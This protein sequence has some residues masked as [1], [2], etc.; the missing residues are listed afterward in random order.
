[1]GSYSAMQAWDIHTIKE[2]MDE[3]STCMY[4]FWKRIAHLHPIIGLHTTFSYFDQF[5][6]VILEVSNNKVLKEFVASNK[7]TWCYMV[8]SG[9]AIVWVETGLDTPALLTKF[10][11]ECVLHNKAQQKAKVRDGACYVERIVLS[12]WY[13][14][15]EDF[16]ELMSQGK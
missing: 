5:P 15:R 2:N 9:M 13:F 11:E 8:H 10:K 6:Y 4:D 3:A 14:N 12:Q 7:I 16:T 1:M